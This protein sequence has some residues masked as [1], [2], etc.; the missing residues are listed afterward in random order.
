MTAACQNSVRSRRPRLRTRSNRLRSLLLVGIAMPLFSCAGTRP[1][2]LGPTDGRLRACPS[3]PNCVSSDADK[4]DTTHYVAPLV[5]TAEPDAAW[6]AAEEAVGRIPRTEI[7]ASSPG[8]LHA[9]CTSALM[10]Y[11]DDLEL[12]MRPSDG[13]IAVRSASRIGYG[14]M[15]VNRKRVEDLRTDLAGNGTVQAAD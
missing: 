2:D 14:D 15:G 13:V 8:Y 5:L 9:E 11:V 7:V 10:G 4:S 6:R 3:S 1:T 12:H